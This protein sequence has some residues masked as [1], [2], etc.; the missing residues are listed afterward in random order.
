MAEKR[1]QVTIDD[2]NFYVVGNENEDYIKNLAKDLTKR[3]QTTSN[4]NYRLNQVQSIV[5]SA[6]NILDELEESKKEQN[7]V[8]SAV[9]DEK[10]VVEQRDENK[11]LREENVQISEELQ[12][13]K[14]S[15]F[16]LQKKQKAQEDELR[17]AHKQV[18]KQEEE[19]RDLK[20][21]IEKLERQ[22][23]SLSEQNYLSQKKII[24]LSRELESIHEE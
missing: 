3:I 13:A 24:D 7:F 20:T 5:L 10:I 18:T 22:K 21:Q 23:E 11:K 12:R 17:D 6:L 14:E 8:K 4:K 19:I 9:G 15:Y 16:N 2:M 1:V